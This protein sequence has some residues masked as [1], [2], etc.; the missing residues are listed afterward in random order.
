M[1]LSSA[2]GLSSSSSGGAETSA[3]LRKADIRPRRPPR[4]IAHRPQQLAMG[5]AE[6]PAKLEGRL[7]GLRPEQ[8]DCGF[9]A[10]QLTSSASTG[11]APSGR[12]LAK[13]AA[14]LHVAAPA[15]GVRHA[16]DISLCAAIGSS[17]GN[18]RTNA[19]AAATLFSGSAVPLPRGTKKPSIR[20][21]PYNEC[22]M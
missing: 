1:N 10:T 17:P 16:A 4:A 14:G 9:R 8:R 22:R 5:P 15:D 13:P 20:T 19:S 18:A 7:R 12:G 2:K 6:G 21:P 11:S 3:A